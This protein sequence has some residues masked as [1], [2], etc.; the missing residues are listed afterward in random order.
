MGDD[1]FFAFAERTVELMKEHP[2]FA[3][4]VANGLAQALVIQR[5]PL[6]LGLEWRY[7]VVEGGWPAA[8]IQA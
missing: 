8:S 5:Y 3:A 6:G 4:L 1:E 2:P 7:R